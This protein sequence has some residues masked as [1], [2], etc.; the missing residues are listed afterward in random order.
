LL[1]IFT[2]NKKN[3]RGKK[4][5]TWKGVKVRKTREWGRL[6]RSGKKSCTEIYIITVEHR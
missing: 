4:I 2:E 3:P 5:Q 6:N 1:D